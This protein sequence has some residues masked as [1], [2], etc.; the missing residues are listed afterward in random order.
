MSQLGGCYGGVLYNLREESRFG[1]VEGKHVDRFLE[2]LTQ[3]GKGTVLDLGCGPLETA[4]LKSYYVGEIVSIDAYNW[5]K[6]YGSN[7]AL[8]DNTSFA[9]ADIRQ[10][11]F[12]GKS[13]D[14]AIATG[15]Y[16]IPI[17][18]DEMSSILQGESNQNY[19]D[20]RAS[21]SIEID[22]SRGFLLS[23]IARVLKPEGLLI[24]S[25]SLK[26]QPVMETREKF[27]KYFTI[28]NIDEG[29]SR[30]LMECRLRI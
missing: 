28:E 13:A 19:P 25:N 7:M 10:L 6:D 3:Y 12:K 1:L 15:V 14:L 30:Y 8:P 22:R 21:L 11:P 24:V 26:H 5:L 16:A 9:L 4:I 20:K 23:E 2:L 27:E 17:P 18:S 29:C